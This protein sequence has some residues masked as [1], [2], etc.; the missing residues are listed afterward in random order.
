MKI[1]TKTDINE[2]DFLTSTL[3]DFIHN[4]SNDS[5]N[6]TLEKR[7]AICKLND[8][9]SIADLPHIISMPFYNPANWAKEEECKHVF[10]IGFDANSNP[11]LFC[12]H[13]AKINELQIG[14]KQE[15]E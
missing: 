12:K 7:S 6:K 4:L 3:H 5:I 8:I 14:K 15:G 2:I 13:C 1:L 10:E 11:F 9:R